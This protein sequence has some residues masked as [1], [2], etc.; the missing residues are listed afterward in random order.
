MHIKLNLFIKST[1]FWHCSSSLYFAL[2]Q[3]QCHNWITDIRQD[4]NFSICLKLHE[5][6]LQKWHIAAK[7]IFLDQNGLPYIINDTPWCFCNDS[8]N[9]GADIFGQR[10]PC[11]A[12]TTGR[13]ITLLFHKMIK[14]GIQIVLIL[15]TTNAT[16]NDMMYKY[17]P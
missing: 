6:R 10:I 9:Y 12:N 13:L 1:H 3:F 11:S 5:N 4:H 15:T 16:W 7:S 17:N 14:P 8:W 2:H